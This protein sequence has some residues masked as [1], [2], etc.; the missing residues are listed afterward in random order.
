[1][2]KLHKTNRNYSYTKKHKDKLYRLGLCIDCGQK[3]DNLGKYCNHCKEIRSLREKQRRKEYREKGLCV[4]CKTPRL[5]YSNTYCEKH[6]FQSVASGRTGT[7]KNGELIKELFI[8]QNGK[9]AYTGKELKPGL[10]ADLDHK[11]PV[12]KGGSSEISNL[13]WVDSRVNGMKFN[14]THDEFIK[15][16]KLVTVNIG[17]K[18]GQ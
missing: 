2:Y 3:Q 1:M 12:T 11:L 14:Y 9:C 16:C 13:Q 8:K 4:K 15:T 5:E 7:A 10:N 18:N 6:W 17:S